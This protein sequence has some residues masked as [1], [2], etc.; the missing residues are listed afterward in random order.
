MLGY[1]SGEY[2][3][4]RAKDLRKLDEMVQKNKEKGNKYFA[5]VIYADKLCEQ[6]GM[7]TPLKSAEDRAKIMEQILGVDFTFVI[8]SLDEDEINKKAIKAFNEYKNKSEKESV[9]EEKKYKNVYVPG[10]YDLF[11]AGHL[12][13]LMEASKVGENII[14]GVKADEVVKKQKGEYPKINEKERMEILK[15]F[16]FVKDAFIFY[17]RDLHVAADLVNDRYGSIPAIVCGADLEKDYKNIKDL[18]II[19][20]DRDAKKMKERSTSTYKKKLK[21]R[22]IKVPYEE[23]HFTGHIQQPELINSNNEYE[24]SDDK[25]EI[26]FSNIKNEDFIL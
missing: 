21:L 9:K 8:D 13:N 17:T 6:L 4:L 5:V 24:V 14:A 1:I 7:D 20:T 19:Y 22:E 18:N 3:I 15:H 26:D 12:E 11:H 16:K 25:I 2:D 23:Q 10:T